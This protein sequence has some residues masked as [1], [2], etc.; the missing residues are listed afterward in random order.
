MTTH[1]QR[2]GPHYSTVDF[3]DEAELAPGTRIASGRIEVHSR[4]ARGGIGIVYR[5][6]DLQTG[7]AVAVKVATSK[8]STANTEA[9]FRNEARL[10]GN[11]AGLPYVVPVLAV[12]QLDEPGGFAGRMWV[13]S[14]LVRGGSL[15]DE[16]RQNRTGLDVQRACEIARDVARALVVL[17]ERG[18][19]HRDIK[20][21]NVM[22]EH[23]SGLARVLDFGLAFATGDGWEQRS[24]DL[25]AGDVAPGTPIY[26][27]P[28][29]AMGE[30]PS[31]PFDIYALG[32]LIYELVSGDP[33][34]EGLP[35]GHVIAR[36][37]DPTARP[38]PLRKM[39]PR[40]PI[41]LDELVQQCM[42]FEPGRRPTAAE[43]VATLDTLIAPTVVPMRAVPTPAADGRDAPADA[44]PDA[45][46][47]PGRSRRGWLWIFV[48]LLPLVLGLLGVGLWSRF[49]SPRGTDPSHEPRTPGVTRDRAVEAGSSGPTP[50]TSPVTADV[51]ADTDTEG[52]SSGQ[53]D[54]DAAASSVEPRAS[55]TGD[56]L[57]AP[58][59]PA[60]EPKPRPKT[61]KKAAAPP[62][63]DERRAAATRAKAGRQWARVLAQTDD[64]E[65]WPDRATRAELR[66]RAL[67]E[68][69]R[70]KACTKEAFSSKNPKV[71]EWG[72]DCH[73]KT[74]APQ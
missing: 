25:T 28:Q 54:T 13:M 26:M 19:V 1:Q 10:G 71:I 63:C 24:P 55:E 70:Y 45:P 18:V 27:S 60:N 46:D 67:M 36:K 11:L 33:P 48:A 61:K 69:G 29:Q 51:E 57:S 31:P 56:E 8:A 73:R 34:Y 39:C 47:E 15:D 37:C 21:G 50:A 35:P 52:D 23:G 72:R 12:G 68:L 42:S 41:A 20:P 6:H 43:V 5:A 9:R 16:V 62:T 3:E 38:Y 40:A 30:R 32:V 53:A 7:E 44:N 49:V 66:V 4:I 65:C 64:A 14:E 22:L 17:H 74:T 59:P 58:K 2:S